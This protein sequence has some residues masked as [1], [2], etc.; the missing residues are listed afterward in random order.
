MVYT[1]L[2]KLRKAGACHDRY[3]HLVESLGS[4]YADDTPID[5]CQIL[6]TNGLNDVLW[7][8]RGAVDGA[9]IDMR[10]LLFAVACCQD[11]L[12]LMPDQRSRDAVRVAHLFA[13]G[14]AT[15]KEL[16]AARAAAWDVAWDAARAA[17]REKQAVHFRVI[18]LL[19][20]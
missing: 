17:A 16:A 8:P 3:A 9:N 14:E 10:Y 5:L 15:E 12:H 7:I 11:V 19:K 18:F 20:F 2:K 1:T 4:T 13:H 6:D